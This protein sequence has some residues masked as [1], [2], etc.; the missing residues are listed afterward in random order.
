VL[1]SV[2]LLKGNTVIS[3]PEL[4]KYI[5]RTGFVLLLQLT[6]S[7]KNVLHPSLLTNYISP[8]KS[9]R[10]HKVKSL[11]RPSNLFVSFR[12]CKLYLCAFVP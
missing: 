12:G 4:K 1:E 3:N 9:P 6:Q 10:P 11:G 7:L 2:P 8:S 5:P